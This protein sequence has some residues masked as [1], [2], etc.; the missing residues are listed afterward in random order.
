[1]VKSK[2][3]KIIPAD[4][5]INLERLIE[6]LNPPDKIKIEFNNGEVIIRGPDKSKWINKAIPLIKRLTGV[7]E[8]KH[9]IKNPA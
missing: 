4:P 1:K 8:V 5:G 6:L 3:R 7:K 9:K 2:W